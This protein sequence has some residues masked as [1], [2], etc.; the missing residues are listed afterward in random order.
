MNYQYKQYLACKSVWI[1]VIIQALQDAAEAIG[2]SRDLDRAVRLEMDYF[3]SRSFENVCD[4]AEIDIKPEVIEAKLRS[5]RN[6]KNKYW[7]KCV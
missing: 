6:W 7:R 2:R 5:L 3:K 4:L 1:M